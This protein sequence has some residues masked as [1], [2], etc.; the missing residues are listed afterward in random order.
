MYEYK[1]GSC[2][3]GLEKYEAGRGG[4]SE[5]GRRCPQCGKGKLERVFS[6]FSSNACGG[7][8]TVSQGGGGCGHGGFS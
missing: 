1:C 4:G 7:V 8:G 5:E 2:G 3:H 6:T